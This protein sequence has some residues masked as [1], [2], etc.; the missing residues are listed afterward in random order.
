MKRTRDVVIALGVSRAKTPLQ[1]CVLILTLAELEAAE[2]ESERR[3][4]LWWRQKLAACAPVLSGGDGS[5]RVQIFY[6]RRS[7]YARQR[8]NPFAPKVYYEHFRF[9]REDI[10]RLVRALRMPHFVRTR[11]GCVLDGEEA[12]LIFLKVS[13]DLLTRFP[14]M[15]CHLCSPSLPPRSACPIQTGSLSYWTSSDARS[16]TCPRW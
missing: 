5:D 9:A 16:V 8:V 2:A 1:K 12:L 4:R 11:S 6:G 7:N 13:F 15:S 14:P 10:P 3:R